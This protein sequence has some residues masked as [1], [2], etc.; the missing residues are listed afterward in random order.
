[1]SFVALPYNCVKQHTAGAVRKGISLESLLAKSH[2]HLRYGD[3]RDIVSPIQRLLLC[4]TTAFDLGDATHGLARAGVGTSYS[5][6]GLRMALG[7]LNLEEAIQALARLYGLASSAVHIQLTTEQEIAVLSVHMDTLDEKDVAYLEENFLIW[8]F[9]QCMHF[10]GRPPPILAVT[11]RDPLHFSL[12]LS[13]W[14]IR[15]P[16]R[17]GEVTS[18]RF[19]KRL[20]SE[21]PSCRAGENVLWEA[22][23]S[24]IALVSEGTAVAATTS[25]YSSDG[26][27]RF[28]D[29][30]RDAGVSATT[31]RRRFQASNGQFREARRRAL[32]Q[33]ASDR[34]CASDDSVQTIAA[35]LGYSDARSLRHFLKIATGLTPQQIRDRR[36]IGS[37]DEDRIALVQLRAICAKMNV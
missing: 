32:V 19:P 5:A 27:L 18:F 29:M 13:H 17:Y 35:E 31:L 34:L 8:M 4:V 28:S 6:I 37:L 20:L 7:S 10:L 36:G 21:P 22:T 24:Y 26:F 33:A 2:I 16:V 30:V 15:A 25:Y 12:G 3:D 14:A 9:M 1:M 23:P 11:L